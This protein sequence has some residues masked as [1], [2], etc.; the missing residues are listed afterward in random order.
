MQSESDQIIESAVLT[1]LNS[2]R[3]GHP[4]RGPTGTGSSSTSAE[5]LPLVSAAVQSKDGIQEK[6]DRKAAA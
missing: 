1:F 2:D 4:S 3:R 5:F 6:K